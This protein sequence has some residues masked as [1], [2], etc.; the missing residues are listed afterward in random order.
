MLHSKGAE[1]D[2]G[3]RGREPTALTLGH[4]HAVAESLKLVVDPDT[5]RAWNEEGSSARLTGA[6]LSAHP[7]RRRSSEGGGGGRNPPKYLWKTAWWICGSITSTPSTPSKQ[8]RSGHSAKLL[9]STQAGEVRSEPTACT[10]CFGITDRSRY[11][12]RRCS[13]TCISRTSPD[14]YDAAYPMTGTHR[15]VGHDSCSGLLCGHPGFRF[16]IG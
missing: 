10:S 5:V 3:F 7:T 16:L 12:R 2:A 1:H 11:D 14:Q 4:G 9:G 15:D 8:G 6:S 13:G